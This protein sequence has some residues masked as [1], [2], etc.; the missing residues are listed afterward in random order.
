MKTSPL[1]AG[2]G[3]DMA[4]IGRGTASAGT[5]LGNGLFP[6]GLDP[7]APYMSEFLQSHALQFP[8][9]T[10]HRSDDRHL[11]V[12]DRID[13]RDP[14]TIPDTAKLEQ[15]LGGTRTLRHARSLAFPVAQPRALSN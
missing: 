5:L 2:E 13:R 6:L 1:R 15:H 7:F 12:A 11:D 10:P 14:Q 9:S 4:S 3:P 8:F